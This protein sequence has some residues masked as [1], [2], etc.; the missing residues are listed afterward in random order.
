LKEVIQ[1]PSEGSVIAAQQLMKAVEHMGTD[2]LVL[3]L[4]SGGGSSLCAMPASGLSLRDKQKITQ[5]LLSR[6]ATIGEINVVRENTFQRLKVGRL[7]EAAYP[8]RVVTLLIS[9]IPGDDPAL[10]CIWHNI[11]RP[12]YLRGRTCCAQTVR[13]RRLSTCKPR[14]VSKCLGIDQTWCSTT[15]TKYTSSCGLRQGM[16]YLLQKHQAGTDGLECH[17]LSDAMEGEARDLALSHAAIALSVGK[18]QHAF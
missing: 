12:H 16:G 2:D 17:I 7:A 15:N 5:D 1:I 9:D 10:N 4:I 13:Y 3:A 11:A 6:G 8:A 14:A 18:P